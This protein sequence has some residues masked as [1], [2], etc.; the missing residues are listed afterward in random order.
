MTASLAPEIEPWPLAA[1]AAG[2]S[3]LAFN[4]WRVVLADPG[5][6]AAAAN[7][8]AVELRSLV[9]EE[10]NCVSVQTTRQ[11]MDVAAN[12]SEGALILS[13]DSQLGPHDWGLVDINRSRLMRGG[14]TFLV[15]SIDDVSSIVSSAPNLWSWVGGDVWK[16][17]SCE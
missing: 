11:L 13:I 3:G 14:A 4:S 8:I 7:A 16:I 1:R 2:M 5:R 15:V 10:V 17:V 9:D 12:H 6:E